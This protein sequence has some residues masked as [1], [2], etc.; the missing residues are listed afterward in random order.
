MFNRDVLKLDAERECARIENWIR[1]TIYQ[2][3][4]KRGGVV[5]VSGGIDSSVTYALVVRALGP[6]RTLAIAMPE[7]ESSGDSLDLARELVTSFGGTMLT[8]D[9]TGALEGFGAYRRREDAA[10]LLFPDF[11]PGWKMKITLPSGLL[12]SG[13]LNVFHLAVTD[14]EGRSQSRRM[15][16]ES[17]LQV[18]AASNFKQRCRM[19]TLYYHAERSNYAVVGTP[20]LDEDDQ[21]FFVKYGDGGVDLRPIAHLY[22]T[23]VF[24]LADYLGVPASIRTRTPTTDTYSDEVTQEE[25][26]FRLPFARMDLLLYAQA[27]G[28]PAEET[29]EALGMTPE[30]VQHAWRD[31]DQKRKTAAYLAA[32]PRWIHAE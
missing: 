31:F 25:F 6:E 18:V 19:A 13:S 26:F 1:E 27:Q 17:L 15:T 21:G 7:K 29:A 16:S 9:L 11:G 12:E 8:E 24:Q 22:K 20:N 5:G 4:K 2:E 30:Q 10:R 23:Q 14:P 3:F 28:V 32:A